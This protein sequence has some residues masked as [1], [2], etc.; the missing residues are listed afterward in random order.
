MGCD[1]RD[2][3]SGDFADT[4]SNARLGRAKELGKGWVVVPVLA[5]GCSKKQARG[6]EGCRNSVR[7][8]FNAVAA[9]A[10]TRQP[11]FRQLVSDKEVRIRW[12]KARS[13]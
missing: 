13:Q 1:E 10:F 9:T 8:F 12:R 6:N 5:H 2:R 3:L 7:H 4:E 11:P